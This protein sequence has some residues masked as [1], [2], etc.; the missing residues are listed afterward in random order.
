[1]QYWVMKSEPSDYSIGDLRYDKKTAWTG[2]R[3]YQVR[4][5]MRDDIKVGDKVLFYHS[6]TVPIGVVGE[7]EVVSKAYP[8]PTQFEPKD[9]HY[10]SKS[11]KENPRWLCVDV[12]F[13][14]EFSRTVTLQEIKADKICTDMVIARK[15]S[16]LSVSLVTREQFNQILYL[17]K[18]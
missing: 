1:M 12:K 16:R 9:I 4:N 10:D 8:D 7:V 3:N 2:I 14:K 5:M 17:A 13:V 15:G 18:K 6:N 11:T